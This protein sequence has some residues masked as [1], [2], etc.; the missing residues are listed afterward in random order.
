MRHISILPS[1]LLERLCVCVTPPFCHTLR[2]RTC[3]NTLNTLGP[4]PQC[5]PESHPT[6]HTNN[7][8]IIYSLKT[9]WGEKCLYN[10]Y[11]MMTYIQFSDQTTL[12]RAGL[13]L[14]KLLQIDSEP[15]QPPWMWLWCALV[16][17]A[18]SQYSQSG[19]INFL[20]ACPASIV[21]HSEIWPLL[22]THWRPRGQSTIS[23][24]AS[25]SP[26]NFP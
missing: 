24:S 18:K 6:T 14:W 3:C 20:S 4:D 16:Y 22:F 9:E 23:R 1:L 13:S 26:K 25:S 11:K 2:C 5:Y 21:W 7:T 19:E 12:K 15:H 17:W 8:T 10:H